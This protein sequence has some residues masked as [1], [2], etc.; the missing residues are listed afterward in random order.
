MAGALSGI[1]VLDF[2]RAVAGAYTTMLLSDMGAEINKVEIVPDTDLEAMDLEQVQPTEAIAHFWGL[3]RGK[4]G[5]CLDMTKP[6]AREIAYDLVKVSDV[7]HDNFRPGVLDRLGIDYDTLKQHNPKIISCSL[8]GYGE[9]GPHARRASYDVIVQALCGVMSMT[10]ENEESMPL[11]CGVAIGDLAG[12]LFAA[13]GI[14][15]ALMSRERTGVGQRVESSIYEAMLSFES[16]RVPQVFGAGMNFGPHPRRSGAGQVPYGPFKTKDGWICLAAGS[17]NFWEALCKTIGREDL[18]NN[19]RFN[20]LDRRRENEEEISDIINEA[21]QTKTGAEWEEISGEIGVPIGKV[22]NIEE[23]FMHPQAQARDM[24]VSFD[25]PLGKK[26]KCAGNPIKMSA[27]Q[28]EEYKPAPGIGEHTKEILSTLLGY[29]EE[30]IAKLRE[31]RAIWY[32]YEGV[33]YGTGG[34]LDRFQWLRSP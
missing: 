7:V 3:N 27:T 10:G 32:P 25:H 15:S 31:E 26:I 8:S 21:T 11:P 14:A 30:K 16:Y 22:N 13:F 1:R 24:L 23:A 20:T 6:S 28:N 19:P 33:T 17:Q 34:P 2:G 29:P 5:L 4:R 18:I 9:N 12:G